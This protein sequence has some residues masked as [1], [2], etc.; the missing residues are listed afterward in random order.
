MPNWS[1]WDIDVFTIGWIV[2]ILFFAVWETVG[3]MAGREALTNHLRP[4]FIATPPVYFMTVGLWIWMGWHFF[5]EAGHPI[6]TL[7]S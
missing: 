3:I 1:A 6:V 7:G 5:L 2:W 4:V